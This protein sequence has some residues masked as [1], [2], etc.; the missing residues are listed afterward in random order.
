MKIQYTLYQILF[1]VFD[2]TKLP[3]VHCY[4]SLSDKAVTAI[5]YVLLP[6]HILKGV[7]INIYFS[8]NN[9]KFD[10]DK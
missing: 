2:Y 7:L 6:I 5:L 10:V 4:L 9:S 8:D 3:R 1:I